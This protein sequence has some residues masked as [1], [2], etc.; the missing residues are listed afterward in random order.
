MWT[1]SIHLDAKPRLNEKLA[2]GPYFLLKTLVRVP[3]YFI[4][5]PLLDTR[6]LVLLQPLLFPFAQ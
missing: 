4:T 6:Q 1:Y 2:Q 3:Q 5:V